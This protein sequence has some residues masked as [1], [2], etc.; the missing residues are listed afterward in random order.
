MIVL[1][2]IYATRRNT[3]R[4]HETI[5]VLFLITASTGAKSDARPDSYR[6]IQPVVG[7][8]AGNADPVNPSVQNRC[9]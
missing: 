4:S 3:L 6:A 8:N 1:T 7:G 9:A 2:L 5:A